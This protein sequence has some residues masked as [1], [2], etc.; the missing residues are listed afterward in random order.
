MPTIHDFRL[1]QRPA[2]TSYNVYYVKLWIIALKCDKSPHKDASVQST[3][4]GKPMKKLLVRSLPVFGLTSLLFSSVAFATRSNAAGTLLS[5][6]SFGKNETIGL[7]VLAVV[8]VG[9]VV[10]L[11]QRKAK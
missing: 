7:L 9:A 11:K 1:I 4:P 2:I 8:A 3:A 10:Y 6:G 5:E